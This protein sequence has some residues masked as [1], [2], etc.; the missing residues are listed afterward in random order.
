MFARSFAVVALT[1]LF[2]QPLAAQDAA[3]WTQMPASERPWMETELGPFVSPILGDMTGEHVTFFRFPGGAVLPMHTHEHGYNGIVVAGVMRHY[4]RG[5]DAEAELLPAGSTWSFA[6]GVEHV[7]EC[8]AG[9]E[10]IAVMIQDG[11]FDL[12]YVE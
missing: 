7:S 11:A 4:L 12:R 5:H 9:A 2:T 1:A 8:V 3:D 10:C 6:G